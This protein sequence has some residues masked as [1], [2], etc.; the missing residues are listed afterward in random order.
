MARSYIALWILAL[1]SIQAPRGYTLQGRITVN[2]PATSIRV[3]LED[4]K[5]RPTEV[6]NVS[7]DDDGEYRIEGLPKRAYR[8]VAVIEGK[9]QDRKD[10]DIICRPGA[11][12]SKDF[13][14]GKTPSTLQLQFPAEDPDT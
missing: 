8:L 12:V 7:V 11:V 6:A 3:V 10:I 14:Y 1:A 4:P 5:A 9:R 13:H 2:R